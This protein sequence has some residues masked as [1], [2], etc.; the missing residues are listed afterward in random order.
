M[1]KPVAVGVDLGGTWVR[2]AA[3]SPDGKRA[4]R[5]KAP[6]PALAGLPAFLQRLWER[7]GLRPAEVGALVVASRGVWTP[8]ERRRQEEYLRPLAEKVRVTSDVEAAYRS[9]LGDRPG[10]LVLAGTGSIALGR[11][12]RRRWV[13]RGGMGPLLGDE[14]SA[15]W[16]G[17]EYLRATTRGE[18][19]APVRVIVR[20]PNAV[21]RIAALAPLVLRRARDGDR[22]CRT[23]VGEA[24]GHLAALALHVARSLRLDYPVPVSWAGGL[25]ENPA[26]R[27][28]FRRALKALPL[29]FQLLPPREEPHLA[30]ARLA[31]RLLTAREEGPLYRPA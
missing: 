13:R 27:A 19:F 5:L 25:L 29:A 24:Q 3:L 14:G 21:A 31:L 15:F 4:R 8:A 10:V 11:D 30:A 1:K 26:F 28:G 6:A 18:D 2:V 17:R 16:M 9:A 12:R 7:W 20:S 23:I 22:T